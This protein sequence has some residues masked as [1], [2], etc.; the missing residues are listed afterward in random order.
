MHKVLPELYEGHAPITLQNAFHDALEGLEEWKEGSEEPRVV[1]DGVIVPISHVL[2]G[3]SACT[4]LVPL[5]TRGVLEGIIDRDAVCAAAGG[6]VFADA[7]RLAM[8]LV[9]QRLEYAAP[10]LP[11]ATVAQS[12]Q[13][14]IEF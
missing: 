4:D 13:A 1:V 14:C 5:R 2:V 8:A 9:V 7:A 3:M 11:A 12:H 6:L 10:Q